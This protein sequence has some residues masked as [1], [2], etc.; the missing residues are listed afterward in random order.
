MSEF[1]SPDTR[2]LDIN[3]IAYSP[4]GNLEGALTS[5]FILK[6]AFD[7]GI[8]DSAW[9]AIVSRSRKYMGTGNTVW[10]IK[11]E[12]GSVFLECYFFYPD[13]YSAHTLEVVKEIIGPFTKAAFASTD[14]VGR[15]QCLSIDIAGGCIPGINVYRLDA[16][17]GNRISATSWFL[18]PEGGLLVPMNRYYSFLSEL[19]FHEDGFH[20]ADSAVQIPLSCETLF[21]GTDPHLFDIWK[22]MDY[23]RT[24]EGLRWPVGVAEKQQALG[25]YF[26]GLSVSEF[27]GFLKYHGYPQ[28]F[29]DKVE[30]NKNGLSHIRYDIGID[31]TVNG[32]S[33]EIVKTA[34]FGSM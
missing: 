12:R 2:Y 33:V 14:N 30:E 10:G 24:G 31:Y 25:I 22:E 7:C 15:Y 28:G 3:G 8:L 19:G 29:I 23:L 4:N 32:G 17:E 1:H 34:F 9:K 20:F 16:Q 27:I 6:S 11:N 21:P 26:M 18:Y 13:I 5:A